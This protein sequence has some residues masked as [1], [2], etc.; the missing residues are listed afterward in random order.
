MFFLRQSGTTNGHAPPSHLSPRA[1]STT[2]V[3]PKHASRR[4]PRSRAEFGRAH[5]ALPASGIRWTLRIGLECQRKAG[6]RP[7]WHFVYVS[8][9]VTSQVWEQAKDASPTFTF[10]AEVLN[11]DINAQHHSATVVTTQ[12]CS[13]WMRTP[14]QE[15]ACRRAHIRYR[16]DDGPVIATTATRSFHEL[17]SAPTPSP[18]CWRATITKPSAP[19]TFTLGFHKRR[20]D[21]YGPQSSGRK[22]P[23][24][25]PILISILQVLMGHNRTL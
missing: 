21:H 25:G 17:S 3:N 9:L 23:P 4:A 18:S 15:V 2:G 20:D 10:K 1:D 8:G 14:R 16:V 13:W 22:P 12:E 24:F 19:I 5:D 6:S 11:A 7:V